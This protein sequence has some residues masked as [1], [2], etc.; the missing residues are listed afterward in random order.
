MVYCPSSTQSG[1]TEDRRLDDHQDQRKKEK[2]KRTWNYV[3]IVTRSCKRAYFILST[4]SMSSLV[5]LVRLLWRV[6]L[7]AVLVTSFALSSRNEINRSTASRATIWAP[8]DFI[9]SRTG[10]QANALF[11]AIFYH[12]RVD[13]LFVEA[14]SSNTSR[15]NASNQVFLGTSTA[16]GY[17]NVLLDRGKTRAATRDPR[18]AVIDPFHIF[19]QIPRG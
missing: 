4:R 13:F 1:R 12:P 10:L 17:L 8:T 9:R 14:W 3:V 6:S 11:F 7:R 16:H 15:S 18:V 5:S 19:R 2:L